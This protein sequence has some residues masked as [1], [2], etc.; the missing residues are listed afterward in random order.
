MKKITIILIIITIL[1]CNFNIN[2]NKT[3]NV[4]LDNVSK[5][6]TENV[7][8]KK[9]LKIIYRGKA[10]DLKPALLNKKVVEIA[11][12]DDVKNTICIFVK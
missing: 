12:C 1:G 8:V 7:I 9:D 11:I 2:S 3:N 10:E 4:T 5:L 6:V